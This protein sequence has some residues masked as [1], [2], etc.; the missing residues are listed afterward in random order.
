IWEF[1]R[2]IFQ[3]TQRRQRRIEASAVA[4][5]KIQRWA[6]SNSGHSLRLYETAGGYR[7]LFTDGRFDP[8]SPKVESIFQSLS[9]DPMY[10]HLCQQQECFRARLSPKPWRCGCDHPPHQFPWRDSAAEDATRRWERDY[11][12]KSMSYSVCRLLEAIGS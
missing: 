1:I 2:W 8:R 11:A 9:C 5:Q 3:P 4:R 10:R 7:L 6:T 12:E